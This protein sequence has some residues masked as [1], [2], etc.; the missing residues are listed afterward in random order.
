MT[1][2]DAAENLLVVMALIAVTLAA[3]AHFV[4]SILQAHA[5]AAGLRRFRQGMDQAAQSFA[6][7][8]DDGL[9]DD[10]GEQARREVP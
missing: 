1:W 10:A 4:C 2:W 3:V 6:T 7:A 8:L 9:L 5:A